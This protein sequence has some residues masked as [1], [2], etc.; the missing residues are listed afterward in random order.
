[1]LQSLRNSE[2]KFTKEF[3]KFFGLVLAV[4]LA[5]E[6]GAAVLCVLCIYWAAKDVDKGIKALTV[7]FLIFAVNPV[8]FH[9]PLSTVISLLRIVLI[10]VF[11]GKVITSNR[12][13]MPVYY[14]ALL[15]F[16]LVVTLITFYSSYESMVS[17][18]K[19][20]QFGLAASS[21]LLG[22]AN[23]R[24]T[25]DYWINWFYTLFVLV[26]LLSLPFL[27]I[28]SVGFARNGTGFQ[29]ILN[30]PQAYAV[31]L[32]PYIALLLAEVVFLQR[33]NRF[34]ILMLL[35]GAGSLVLTQGRTGLAAIVVAAGLLII[36]A[37]FF[38]RSLLKQ[39]GTPFRKLGGMV[40]I[41]AIAVLVIFK[42]DDIQSSVYKFLLKRDTVADLKG[43]YNMSRGQKLGDQER[44]IAAHPV[45]GIGFGL[46][47]NRGDLEVQRDPIFDLPVGAT[48]EK[49][50]LFIS[51]FEEIGYIGAFFFYL[52]LFILFR[53]F[54]RAR[55]IAL[56][57][58]VLAAFAT[59]VGEA[60]LFSFGGMGLF[61]WLLFGIGVM[62]PAP[63]VVPAAPSPQP[64]FPPSIFDNLALSK[65]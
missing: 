55:S 9:A 25:V 12:A 7:S 21:I 45:F 13:G 41:L 33:H 39:F 65:S 4:L 44:N 63:E 40:A 50:L 20:F 31:F 10:F 17:I 6:A 64:V 15:G 43:S 62:K 18:S 38:H 1:M 52:F 11:A 3:A 32:S 37:L 60:T 29:G 19:L 51:V 46:P 30:H 2:L 26:V 57:W 35:L 23:S 28:P 8:L 16:L 22:F 5:G 59:N 54:I 49:G 53:Q 48:V 47:S 34:N 27:A 36:F 42:Y 14:K 58:L 61:I 24:K 56:P